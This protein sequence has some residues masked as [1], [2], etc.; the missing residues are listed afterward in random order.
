LPP[1]HAD[2]VFMALYRAYVETLP[3]FELDGH[4]FRDHRPGCLC[5]SCPQ[6]FNVMGFVTIHFWGHDNHWYMSYGGDMLPTREMAAAELIRR[7][8]KDFPKVV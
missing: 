4:L 6:T 1:S 2:A 7:W 3:S 8:G 5:G